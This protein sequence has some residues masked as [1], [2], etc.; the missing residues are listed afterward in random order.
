MNEK[1]AE[2]FE[3]RIGYEYKNVT[4][5]RP[6]PVLLATVEIMTGTPGKGW[7]E[8]HVTQR[9]EHSIIGHQQLEEF[10]AE[11]RL[12]AEIMRQ[13]VAAAWKVVGTSPELSFK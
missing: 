4:M 7:S 6:Y 5:E 13:R 8:P 2:T 11:V 10:Q 1:P 12:R 3:Y 9:F